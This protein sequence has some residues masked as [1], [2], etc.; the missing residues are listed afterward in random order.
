MNQRAFT[1]EVNGT[2]IGDYSRR[3]ALV[4]PNGNVQRQAHIGLDE[5]PKQWAKD[6]K[7]QLLSQPCGDGKPLSYHAH[8]VASIYGAGEWTVRIWN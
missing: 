4:A 2:I 1:E 5:D 3:V 6:Q 8:L 7:S